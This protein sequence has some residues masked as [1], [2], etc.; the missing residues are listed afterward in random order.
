MNT[1]TQVIATMCRNRLFEE[2][3]LI[4]PFLRVG[5]QWVDA[6]VRSGHRVL[7]MRINSMNNLTPDLES[8]E[9]ADK[10]VRLSQT[11]RL[12]CMAGHL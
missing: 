4:A 5:H 2:K 7:N 1:V 6:V 3:W 8:L 11:M 10:E 12:H 9:M